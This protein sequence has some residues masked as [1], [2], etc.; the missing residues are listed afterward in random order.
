MPLAV[1]ETVY[2]S[3]PR[4]PATKPLETLLQVRKRTFKTDAVTLVMAPRTSGSW[5]GLHL[6]GPAAASLGGSFQCL[7]VLCVSAHRENASR[8][9][10]P[11]STG[12]IPRGQAITPCSESILEPGPGATLEC[13]HKDSV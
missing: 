3:S 8:V 6:R 10:G 9:R 2:R 11:G 7:V 12:M 5:L 13:F 1:A 4:R